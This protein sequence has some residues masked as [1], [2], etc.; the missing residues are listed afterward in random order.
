MK[1]PPS[2]ELRS[3][4][5]TIHIGEELFLDASLQVAANSQASARR[6]LTEALRFAGIQQRAFGLQ[7]LRIALDGRPVRLTLPRRRSAP[8]GV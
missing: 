8:A 4:H 3:F 5:V 6:K 2:K 7:D 1:S